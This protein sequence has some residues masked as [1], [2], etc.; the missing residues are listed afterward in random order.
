[1]KKFLAL[2][3]VGLLVAFSVGVVGA[4]EDYELEEG[5]EVGITAIEVELEEGAEVGATEYGVEPEDGA[6]AVITETGAD[7]GK[8][9]SE[10]GT[11]WPLYGGIGAAV[12]ACGLFIGLRKKS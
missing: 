4:V 11:N 9:E 12:L 10:A 1:M 2:L 8:E 3:V 7:D 6:D 5:A